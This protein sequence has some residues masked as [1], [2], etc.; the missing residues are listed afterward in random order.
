MK[1]FIV[2]TAL[3]LLVGYFLS[4]PSPSRVENKKS[5]ITHH[6]EM[7][8]EAEV[9]KSSLKKRQ[10]TAAAVAEALPPEVV[11]DSELAE[12]SVT[13]EK[14]S[15]EVQEDLSR[16]MNQFFT[17]AQ[18]EALWIEVD[19]LAQDSPD[20]AYDKLLNFHNRITVSRSA[21]LWAAYQSR[22][23]QSTNELSARLSKPER[24]LT[25][26]YFDDILGLIF[27]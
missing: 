14:L 27:E 5:D 20:A 8:S 1:K 25:A 19:A 10:A 11:D 24:N 17:E 4:K 22:V 21:D 23:I 2:L 9:P 12:I 3:V 15:F 26:S 7:I 18:I 16:E 13:E 6:F